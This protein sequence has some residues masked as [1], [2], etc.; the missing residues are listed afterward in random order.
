[1]KLGQNSKRAYIN[2]N[3]STRKNDVTVLNFLIFFGLSL[4][5][6]LYR[7]ILILNVSRKPKGQ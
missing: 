7:A 5:N 3:T 4:L 1:M 6:K 2:I